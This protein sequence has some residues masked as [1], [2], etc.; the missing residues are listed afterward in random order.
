MISTGQNQLKKVW[1]KEY[2]FTMEVAL[3]QPKPFTLTTL[4]I[5]PKGEVR[6]EALWF[7]IYPE[8]SPECDSTS[9]ARNITFRYNFIKSF[10]IP[11]KHDQGSLHCLPVSSEPQFTKISKSNFK[12]WHADRADFQLKMYKDGMVAFKS[13][14]LSDCSPPYD[15]DAKPEKLK[16]QELMTSHGYDPA[17]FSAMAEGAQ[18]MIKSDFEESDQLHV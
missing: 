3:L 4:W 7:K 5:T 17:T 16:L 14:N 12:I 6:K 11:K 9:E 1:Y 18:K 10:F 2:C 15:E 13:F 8:N